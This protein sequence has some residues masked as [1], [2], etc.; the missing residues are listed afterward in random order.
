MI[1]GYAE[2]YSAELSQKVKRGMNETRQKG[3]FTGGTIIYGYKVEKH[4]VVIDEEKAEVVRFIYDQYAQGVVV[5]CLNLIIAYP[6]KIFN[7]YRF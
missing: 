5:F 6:S 4:K 2:Y 3:N 7:C 1:E